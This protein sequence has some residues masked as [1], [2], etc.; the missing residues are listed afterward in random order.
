M[1]AMVM[2]VHAQPE[3]QITAACGQFKL[4]F[5]LIAGMCGGVLDG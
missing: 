3:W 1:I 5:E 2:C 4:H